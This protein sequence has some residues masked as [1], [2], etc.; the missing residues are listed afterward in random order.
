MLALRLE[1]KERVESGNTVDARERNTGLRADVAQRFEGQVFVGM[2]F[3]HLFQDSE[4]GS[5]TSAAGG[6]NVVDEVSFRGAD[7]VLDIPHTARLP[8]RH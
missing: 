8:S 7:G 2:V 4:Q 3:L 5:R 6:N 1:V